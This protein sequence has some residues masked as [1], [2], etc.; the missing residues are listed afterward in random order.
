M[1]ILKK[2]SWMRMINLHGYN[3]PLNWKAFYTQWVFNNS[4]L[5][6]KHLILDSQYI[7]YYFDLREAS[8]S[9]VDKVI[10]KDCTTNYASISVK[11]TEVSEVIFDN[12]IFDKDYVCMEFHFSDNIKKITFKN[13]TFKKDGFLTLYSKSKLASNSH[14]K[15]VFDTCVIK[16]STTDRNYKWIKGISNPIEYKNCQYP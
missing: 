8:T 16:H 3:Y 9:G 15:I 1:H 10:F 11:E 5:Q 4:L 14:I 6:D 7:Y 13:M 2:I 12:V